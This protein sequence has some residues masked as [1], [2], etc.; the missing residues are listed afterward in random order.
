[1]YRIIFFFLFL[2]SLTGSGLAQEAGKYSLSGRVVDKETDGGVEF[3]NLGIEGT[4]IGIACDADGFFRIGIPT[5]M[6]DKIV[7][8]S[9]VGFNPIRMAVGELS[10]LKPLVLKMVPQTYKLSDVEV[11]AQSRVAYGMIK[12]VIDRIS[13]N[14]WQGP[15]FANTVYRSE[16]RS[17]NATVRIREAD[18]EFSDRL[19]YKMR[20][21]KEAFSDRGYRF[22]K[23]KRNFEVRYLSDGMTSMDNL[24]GLDIVRC[25]GNILDREYMND[26]DL[27]LEPE[28]MYEGKP[29]YVVHYTLRKSDFAH[30]GDFQL[31][32]LDGK[33]LISKD[34]YAVLHN[35]FRGV[36][37][38]WSVNGRSI[39]SKDS[40]NHQVSYETTCSYVKYGSA[41]VP[42]QMSLVAHYSTAGVTASGNQL[43]EVS[44]LDFSSYAP[45]SSKD[46][47]GR[48]YFEDT[49]S[50]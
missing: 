43:T 2:I 10:Q 4:Y 6:K 26:F 11:S 18:V 44:T 33:I 49:K 28:T 15:L 45:G 48:V 35:E 9:A 31:K 25:P 29:V 24:L 40:G 50:N 7:T 34:D 39:A 41:Y 36:S 16:V 23:V 22:D 20:D 5:E 47:T 37:Q 8:I 32:S 19:G 30:S 21:H 46:F 42:R 14:Y 17:D 12:N 13:Q 1:M 38:Q 27:S 3:A